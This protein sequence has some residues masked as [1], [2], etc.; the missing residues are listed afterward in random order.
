MSFNECMKLILLI[1]TLLFFQPIFAEVDIPDDIV[2]IDE[3]SIQVSPLNDDTQLSF[4]IYVKEGFFAYK[5][6]FEV[7]IS[8]YKTLPLTIDPIVTF[9][10]KT[11]QKNKEGVR[12]KAHIST[13]IKSE[14]KA[15][16]D[17]LAIKLVYQACTPEYC[18]FPTTLNTHYTLSDADKKRLQVSST[19][20]W[21]KKGLLF[22]ALF[23][24][25]AGFLTSLTPCIYPM[26]PI[27]LAVL[28]SRKTKSKKEGFAKSLV[29][30]LGMATTYATLGILAATSGFMFGSLMA[31]SYFIFALSLLLF[32]AALSMFD[33]FEIQTPRFLQ[34]QLNVNHS[35]GS[36]IAIFVSGLFS[37]LVVGPC[38][39][40]VL[41]GILGYVSQSGSVLYGFILLFSFALGLGSLIVLLG[42]FSSLLEKLPRSGQW[43]NSIKKLIGIVFLLLILYFLAPLLKIRALIICGFLILGAFSAIYLFVNRNVL[44]NKNLAL[45]TYRSLLI[46][47]LLFTTALLSLSDER[48]ERLFG[49]TSST[50]ANTHWQVFSEENLINAKNN[51]QFVVLDFYAEWCAACRELKSLTFSDLRVSNYSEK[52]KW[53]YFDSTQPSEEL[54]KLKE[55]YKILGLPT[56][57]FF[58]QQGNLRA[59]L[60]L[61]G[62]ESPDAFLK[63]LDQL[64]ERKNP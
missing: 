34:N 23:A 7:N 44:K 31:N 48:F 26:L 9:F 49:Y 64:T 29:Y 32:F 62:F 24:F 30:V 22:S 53:L 28:G 41:V 18:L 21:F 15:A 46:F 40:P 61:T 39:G 54:Q 8:N 37:G 20:D 55:K 3:K 35:A 19:P 52:I 43:M 16:S 59:D 45:A 47:S 27:T 57:L 58:D 38:V 51:N 4:D 25:V 12:T 56:I 36:I 14:T 33:V 1:F 2:T 60:T 13:I 63:R 42:T 5:E 50:Y 6:K 10:D 11:F 17:S